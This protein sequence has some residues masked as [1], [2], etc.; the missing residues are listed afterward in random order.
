M[1][2]PES[3]ANLSQAGKQKN[4]SSDSES[5]DQAMDDEPDPLQDGVSHQES[6]DVS[7]A[8]RPA[9]EPSK[10]PT[11]AQRNQTA[12]TNKAEGFEEASGR[13]G[14]GESDLASSGDQVVKTAPGVT[15]TQRPLEESQSVTSPSGTGKK[16]KAANKSMV[17]TREPVLDENA[18]VESNVKQNGKANQK[19]K[20]ASKLETTEQKM[21]C[22]SQT[23]SQ[24]TLINA[25]KVLSCRV[26]ESE[27]SWCF[28]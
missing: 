4:E 14:E 25:H 3:Q 16:S 20:N 23:P 1:I 2:D 22:G 12:D 15:P 8:S 24:V 18:N 27:N 19:G 21:A 10:H 11:G 7:V 17:K 26:N 28:C 6:L 9:A 5:S 13:P